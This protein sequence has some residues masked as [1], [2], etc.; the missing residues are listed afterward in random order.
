MLDGPADYAITGTGAFGNASTSYIYVN[1][2]KTTLSTSLTFNGTSPVVFA[3]PG[4]VNLTGAANQNALSNSTRLNLAG[5]VLRADN[6]QLG[7]AAGPGVISFGGGVL[8]IAGGTNGGGT[9][10][11]TAD[12]TRPLGTLSTG[13]VTW[14]AATGESGSGGFS[15][16]GSAASVNLG[17]Q[18][19]GLTWNVT[20]NFV[21]DGNALKFGSQFS[22]APLTFQN[23]IALDAG[24]AGTYVAREINVTAGPGPGIAPG[25]TGDKTLL[26]GGLSGSSSAD[27]IKTGT[28]TLVLAAADASTGRTIVE[29]GTLAVTKSLAGPVVVAPGGTLTAGTGSGTTTADSI[30]TATTAA[31]TWVGGANASGGT[32]LIKVASA[33]TTA[34]ASNDELVMSGLTLAAT[35]A[36]PFTIALGVANAST[37]VVTLPLGTTLVLAH[38]TDATAANPFNASNGNAATT[39][40][41]LRLITPGV[42]APPGYA[43]QLQTKS[44]PAGGFDLIADDA[45]AAAPEPTSLLLLGLAA[46]PLAL[47]RRRRQCRWAAPVRIGE[48]A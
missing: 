37:G 9:N 48:R 6:A 39:L 13:G 1:N 10:T 43:P 12:F 41:A 23:P 30:S 45:P 22:N 8:E 27:L 42:T 16:Y 21:A 11:G 17:G 26:T 18:T 46:A 3:G 44:D 40:A 14:T 33:A 35:P 19:A 32:V 7:F 2:P 4:V 20:P 5:G 36:T 25:A 47:G 31:Q 28:G 29:A 38:D 34:T 24:T 15:A